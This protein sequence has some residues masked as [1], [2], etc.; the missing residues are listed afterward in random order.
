MRLAAI[1]LGSQL[2]MIFGIRTMRYVLVG[3][4]ALLFTVAGISTWLPIYYERY[5][6]MSEAQATG[7]VGLVLGLGGLI[8]TF[9]GGWFSD[10][11]HHRWKG[12]R[13]V[14][15]VWSSVF[16]AV[17]FM[18]SFAVQ[19]VGGHRAPVHRG[20]GGGGCRPGLRAAMTDVVP[21]D[22]RGSAPRRWP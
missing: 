8:G 10:H 21:P 5:S 14:I 4:A 6:G 17:L 2:K 3:V 13:I 18:I 12:G 15:V 7:V 22:S 9:A 16:C 11:S 20:R 19:P 1:E